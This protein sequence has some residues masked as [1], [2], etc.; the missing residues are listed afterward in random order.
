MSG[1]GERDSRYDGGAE[2][3]GLLRHSREDRRG[4]LRDR[5]SRRN[6]E[7][8]GGKCVD[9]TTLQECAV[10]VI[11]KTKLTEV[12]AWRVFHV[13]RS[14]IDPDGDRDSDAGAA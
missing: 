14:R 2:D 7:R 13:E 12:H 10:K 8:P 11:N 1:L 4:A 5:V 6:G 9:K 3:R